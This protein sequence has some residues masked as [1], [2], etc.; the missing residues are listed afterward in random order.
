MNSKKLQAHFE[1]NPKELEVLTHD[2]ALQP[3]RVMPHL[4]D[5]PDYLVPPT[6][7]AAAEAAGGGVDTSRKR[8]RKGNNSA[9][10]G[11]TAG[12]GAD[13]LKSFAVNA[14]RLGGP[15]GSV[16]VRLSVHC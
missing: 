15:V 16:V 13:P 1:D 8:R 10:T 4:A 7:R 14:N 12:R 5:V 3:A 6:L 11:S 2:K 9:W